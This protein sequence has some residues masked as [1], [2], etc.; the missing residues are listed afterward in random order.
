[1]DGHIQNKAPNTD[2]WD[3]HARPKFG[4]DHIGPVVPMRVMER[5][6]GEHGVHTFDL[7]CEACDHTFEFEA[8]QGGRNAVVRQIDENQDGQPDVHAQCPKCG[9]EWNGDV[10]QYSLVGL[11]TDERHPIENGTGWMQ[12]I[13]TV[14]VIQASGFLDAQT[15]A[16]DLIRQTYEG[17]KLADFHGMIMAPLSIHEYRMYNRM[18]RV[19]QTIRRGE[20]PSEVIQEVSREH[21][22]EMREMQRRGEAGGKDYNPI[23]AALARGM[24]RQLRHREGVPV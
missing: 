8:K 10:V 9:C 22:A 15:K 6:T 17:E 14:G 7:Q 19:E 4:Q 2:K 11:L 12:R 1:M 16:L 21:E 23:E 3:R 24:R 18:D 13:V 5:K 20:D